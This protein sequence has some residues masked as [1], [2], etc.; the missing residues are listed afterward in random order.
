MQFNKAHR[1]ANGIL[2][3]ASIS[4][5]AKGPD[6]LPR[7]FWAVA[8]SQTR[9]RDGD[10]IRQAGW[11]FT[12]YDKNPVGL[13]GHDYSLPPIFA[14]KDKKTV[15]GE[16]WTLNH[17]PEELGGLSGDIY[18]A[19]EAG[20][21]NAF[22]VGF[23]PQSI[24]EDADMREGYGLAREADFGNGILFWEQE[25][26]ELSAVTVPSNPDAVARIKGLVGHEAL[27]DALAH[28]ED[29]YIELTA[30]DSAYDT[31]VAPA[32]Y[33][34][35]YIETTTETHIGPEQIEYM[36]TILEGHGYVVTA[37]QAGAEIELTVEWQEPNEVT[38]ILDLPPEPPQGQSL[39]EATIN[40]VR[41]AVV[42]GHQRRL[43]AQEARRAKRVRDAVEKEVAY[44]KGRV[45]L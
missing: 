23:S 9:D 37:G 14:V 8:S 15:D 28:A 25:L 35:A 19:F 20:V 5:L 18:K 22:S 4:K 26:F 1:S 21:M 38:A 3:L 11:D 24:M 6:D 32:P 29:F 12:H 31:P 16:L 13:W 45:I 41:D 44:H 40:A 30:S 43:E 2:H 17:F 42:A 39:D 27:K 7:S 10:V 34:V 33:P 36:K